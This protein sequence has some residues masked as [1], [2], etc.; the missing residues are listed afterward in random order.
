MLCGFSASGFF[1]A[2]VRGA[3]LFRSTG[4]DHLKSR[5][6]DVMLYQNQKLIT[7]IVRFGTDDHFQTVSGGATQQLEA[8]YVGNLCTP[9]RYYN[10][11][12]FS[13]FLVFPL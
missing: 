12:I 3:Y 13:G 9:T 1:T 7:N 2:P 6:M 8:G 10:H 11:N 4:G 5:S